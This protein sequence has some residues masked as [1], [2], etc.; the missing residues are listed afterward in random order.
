[1]HEFFGLDSRINEPKEITIPS[2]TQVKILPCKFC[3][4]SRKVF[5]V[6]RADRRYQIFC[7]CGFTTPIYVDSIDAVINWNVLN[8]VIKEAEERINNE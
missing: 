2:T 1:M 7:T 6:V 8:K 5:L 3:K 4:D